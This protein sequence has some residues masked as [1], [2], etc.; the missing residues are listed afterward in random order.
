MVVHYTQLGPIYTKA[1]EREERELCA[2]PATCI[3]KMLLVITVN[4]MQNVYSE[5]FRNANCSMLCCGES[6]WKPVSYS[7]PSHILIVNKRG[8]WVYYI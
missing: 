4:T 2:I 6:F 1:V 8:E 7:S 5:Y 3:L